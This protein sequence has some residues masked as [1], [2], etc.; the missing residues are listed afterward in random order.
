MKILVVNAG[1]SSIRYQLFDMSDDSVLAKGQ[2]DRIGI[3]GGN[4]KHKV[5]GRDDYKIDIQMAN[6]AEAVPRYPQSDTEFSTAERSSRAR[7]SL[8]TR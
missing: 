4:F 2:C 3:A 1:S 7:L 5:P 6:H 8:T